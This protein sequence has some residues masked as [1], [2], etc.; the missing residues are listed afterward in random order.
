MPYPVSA[1]VDTC[2]VSALARDQFSEVERAAF[3][4]ILAAS[5]AHYVRLVT[6]TAMKDELD[7]IPEPHRAPHITIY[8]ELGKIPRTSVQIPRSRM[9]PAHLLTSCTY[10]DPLYAQLSRVLDH[11]DAEHAYQAAKEKVGFLV[12]VDFRTF[13]SKS[14][15]VRSICGVRVVSPDQ[16]V[17]VALLAHIP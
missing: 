3:G 6:S 12:T 5:E 15:E 9:M 16:F 14:D 8:Q 7:K 13:I 4:T 2:V 1:Y 10:E 17:Q 11:G